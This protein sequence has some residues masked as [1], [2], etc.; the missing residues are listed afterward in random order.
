VVA[1]VKIVPPLI[2]NSITVHNSSSILTNHF[3]T[4]HLNV[5]ILACESSNLHVFCKKIVM[6][7]FLSPILSNAHLMYSVFL[8]LQSQ[9]KILYYNNVIFQTDNLFFCPSCSWNSPSTLFYPQFRSQW[10]Q[11][12][13]CK[14][15]LSKLCE[16][17]S[18]MHCCDIE[19]RHFKYII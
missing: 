3:H 6:P 5:F 2:P 15:I 11:L 10:T 18:D 13:S 8:F 1:Q 7:F 9:N 4:F 19:C 17:H 12:A 14:G 16:K